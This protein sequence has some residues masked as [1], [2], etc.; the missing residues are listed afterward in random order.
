MVGTAEFSGHLSTIRRGY[1][2][3]LDIGAKLGILRELVARVLAT[4]LFKEKLDEYIKERQAPVATNRDVSAEDRKKKE[5]KDCD[6]LSNGMQA[7]EGHGVG[8]QG[9]NS[10]ELVAKQNGATDHVEPTL[11]YRFLLI[12]VKHLLCMPPVYV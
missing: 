5:C 7:T 12:A 1:Y 8:F 3:L 11:R 9:S 4:G 10:T 2:G 6:M